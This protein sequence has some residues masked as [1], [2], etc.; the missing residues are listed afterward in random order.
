MFAGNLSNLLIVESENGQVYFVE[1]EKQNTKLD[2][3][4]NTQKIEEEKRKRAERKRKK[5]KEDSSLEVVAHADE[6]TIK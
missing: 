1:N 3:I 6:I 4:R 2:E 5:E